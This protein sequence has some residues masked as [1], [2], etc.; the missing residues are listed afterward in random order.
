M[1]S[2]SIADEAAI[3]QKAQVGIMIGQTRESIK[4]DAIHGYKSRGSEQRLFV[5]QHPV[6]TMVIRHGSLNYLTPL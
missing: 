1:M 3:R 6:D 2:F 5:K 4:G